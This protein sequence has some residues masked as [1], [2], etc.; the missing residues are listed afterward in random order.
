VIAS[1]TIPKIFKVGDESKIRVR[2]RDNG[3]QDVSFRAYDTDHDGYI[4]RLEWTVPHLS[5]ET[6]EIIFISKAF[7]LDSNQ[8]VIA[9]IYPQVEAKD[10]NWAT[11]ND[12]QYVRA[13]FNQVLDDSKDITVY[14]RPTDQSQPAGIQV[15]PVYTDQNGNQTEGSQIA[16]F[17]AIDHEGTYRILL[18]GLPTPTGVFDL[19]IAGSVAIDWIVDP[20]G[21]LSG[22][23]YRKKVTISNTNVG[24]SDL[25]YFPLLVNI[26]ETGGG[27]TNI[28]YNLSD[29]TNGYDIRFTDSS[30]TSLLPYEREALSVASNNLT[31]KLWVQVPTVNHLTTTDIYIYYGNS[32]Q[33]GS[34]W[35]A[36]TGS[37]NCST[38][39]EA[40]CTWKEGSSQN[41]DAVWHFKETGTNPTIHDSTAKANDST[42]QTWT[43]TSGPVDGAGGDDGSKWVEFNGSTVFL[44]ATNAHTSSFWVNVTSYDT[45]GHTYPTILNLKTD[46]D[47]YAVYLSDV[48][49]Y[50][51]IS[52]STVGINGWRASGTSAA[53]IGSWNY[54]TVVFDGVDRTNVNSWK[55]YVNGVSKSLTTAGGW[56]TISDNIIYTDDKSTADTLYGTIDE[57]RV[58]SIARSVG[59]INFEYCNMMSTASGTCSGT[60]ELT[61]GSQDTGGTDRYW[62]GGTGNWSDTSHWANASGGGGG[63]SVPDSTTNVHFDSASGGGTATVDVAASAANFTMDTGNTTNVTLGNTLTASGNFTITAGTF[64]VSSGNYALSVAGNW[65][66]AGTFTAR[67]GTTTFSGAAAE[68]LAGSMVGG[69]AFNNIAFSGAGTK[70][71]S[72]NASTTNVTIQ[73]GSGAVTAPSG[74]WSVSGYWNNGATFSQTAGT[75]DFNSSGPQSISGSNTWFGLSVSGT[76]ARTVSFQSGAIQTISGNGSLTFMG[77]PSQTLLLSP[78]TPGSAWKLAVSTT[79]VTQSVTYTSPSY[80]DASGSS[81]YNQTV[82]A[83]GAGD[84]D[85][86][87]NTNWSFGVYSVTITSSGVISYGYVTLSTSSTT[88]GSAYTQVAKND[89][90][91]NERLNV[92]SSDATGGTGWTLASI[93]GTNQYTHEFSTTTGSTWTLLPD[94]S[95]YV[96]ADPAVAPSGTTNF[97]FRV[98]V[99]STSDY[100]QKSITITIQAAA[101]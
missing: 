7:Q 46:I 25:P 80:S 68:T 55:I 88:L 17:P 20:P 47:Y 53:L 36:T 3:D 56:N 32:G 97:D 34:D 52:A 35:T 27:S 96:T 12:G 2:W 95:T 65:S 60:N 23:S 61:F 76:T 78:I 84:S 45:G 74:L 94:S 15:Y 79:N 92:K 82:Y 5:D 29:K 58:A 39:T 44:T 1:T 13:T 50:E 37:G 41:Y 99:P 81:N 90:A 69:N 93:I 18:T 42:V 48:S 77:A 16:A 9:D 101:P 86:G 40:K 62:I 14:A 70:S 6:Y 89:G 87:N 63:Y 49:G 26:A 91:V 54:I 28:G 21:W 33:S 67:S 10:G 85:G 66:N 31:A 75:V 19:K 64:D 22:W 8:N 4:D 100:Q 24:S 38:M 59:W 57:L 98:T 73:A 71:F 83:T 11:I 43:P 51:G 72:N 30:G